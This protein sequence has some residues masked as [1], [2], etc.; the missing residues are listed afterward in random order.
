ML[1]ESERKSCTR[2]R[3]AAMISDIKS[4]E[5]KA[6]HNGIKPQNWKLQNLNEKC[7]GMSMCE[8]TYE[9]SMK[10]KEAFA[11]SPTLIV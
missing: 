7:Q 3:I 9:M 4:F 6:Q 2:S 10:N 11:E 8:Y 1:N 5:H